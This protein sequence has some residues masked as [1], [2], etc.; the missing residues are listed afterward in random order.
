MLSHSLSLSL[1]LTMPWCKVSSPP[2]ASTHYSS[3][4]VLEFGAGFVDDEREIVAELL[5]IGGRRFRGGGDLGV[6]VRLECLR[7]EEVLMRELQGLA[8]VSGSS[9]PSS[10]C[11]EVFPFWV[12][13]LLSLFLWFCFAQP[14]KQSIKSETLN[15]ISLL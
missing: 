6:C 3:Q 10:S 15:P 2:P 14:H 11:I 4:L 9:F 5:E 1:C 8:F 13:A 7:S 12:L